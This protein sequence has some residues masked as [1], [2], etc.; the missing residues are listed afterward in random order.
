MLICLSNDYKQLKKLQICILKQYFKMHKN[1]NCR[2]D[3]SGSDLLIFN[4]MLINW[5]CFLNEMKI[6]LKIKRMKECNFLKQFTI[7]KRLN[8]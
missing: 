1:F 8:I 4:C 5:I 2:F 3:L 6:L 7:L